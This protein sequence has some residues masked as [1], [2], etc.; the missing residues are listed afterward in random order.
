MKTGALNRRVTGPSPGSREA[1]AGR[2][3]IHG[4]SR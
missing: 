1:I 3:H 4:Q 2:L